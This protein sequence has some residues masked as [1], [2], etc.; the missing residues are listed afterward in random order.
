MTE[1]NIYFNCQVIEDRRYTWQYS[2]RCDHLQSNLQL[3]AK[4]TQKLD[5]TQ[6]H[7]EG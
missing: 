1:L 6:V 4:L 3:R 5:L 2:M 7:R